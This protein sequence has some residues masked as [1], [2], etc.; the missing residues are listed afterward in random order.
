LYGDAGFDFLDGGPG[1][2]HYVVVPN[3]GVDM[4]PAGITAA[5]T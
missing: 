1:S 2:D 4:I 5:G 3:W